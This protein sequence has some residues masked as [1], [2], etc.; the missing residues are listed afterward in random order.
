MEG[1]GTREQ[2]VNIRIM[3]EKCRDQNMPLYRC[4]IEFAKAFDC[5]RHRKL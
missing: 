1:K 4:F 3:I 2:I 5:E